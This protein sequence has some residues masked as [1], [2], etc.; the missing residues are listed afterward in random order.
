MIIAITLE[1]ITLPNGL[2]IL[3]QQADFTRC[4]SFGVWIHAGSRF[5][6]PE[7]AGISHFIEHMLF[8]GTPSRTAADIAAFSDRIGGQLNAY[9]AR[10]YTCFYAKTLDTHVTDAFSM[11]ADMILNSHFDE[12]DIETEKGIVSEEINMYDDS[13]EDV[14]ADLLY[15]GVWRSSMLGE[16]ILGSLKSVQAFTKEDI[17][18]Y[19][20][21]TYTPE[22]MVVSICGCFDRDAFLKEIE[23]TFGRLP[24]RG[25]D[26][27]A[28]EEDAAPYTPSLITCPREIEQTH[29]SLA[30]PAFPGQDERIYPLSVLN[31]ALGASS[32][33][34]LFRRLREELGLAYNVYSFTTTYRTAGIFGVASAVSPAAQAQ[35][36]EE[37]CQILDTVR[38]DGLT[39][40]EVARAKEQ[41]E[42][43]IIMGMETTSS[44]AS[45]AGRSE[46]IDGQV[47]P[48]EQVIEKLR[49]VTPE[50]V[51]AVAREVLG[52]S[53]LSQMS[54][55][56]VGPLADD[57][58]YARCTGL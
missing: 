58:L 34:R 54:L 33:S 10:E 9:T 40:D 20:A 15:K 55:C 37:T 7:H 38:R 25:A 6:R 11:L 18:S 56:A 29:L 16:P 4:A 28:V 24:A 21:R 17:L 8:K 23:N 22:R 51:A 3:L 41:M 27:P 43:S 50:K 42:A 39:G 19:R 52:E 1:K 31:C 14:C 32:S 47:L 48:E 30:F 2:R 36:L 46:L 57:G 44:R 35:F 26:T 5:E 49:R 53:Q 12:A 13:P 45:H